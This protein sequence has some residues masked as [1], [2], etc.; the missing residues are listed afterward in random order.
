MIA[1]VLKKS[2]LVAVTV[3]MSPIFV[4]ALVGTHATGSSILETRTVTADATTLSQSEQESISQ[5][6]DETIDIQRMDNTQQE[7]FRKIVEDS[8]KS[9]SLP[10]QSDFDDYVSAVLSVFNSESN[11]YQD[12]S[13]AND[14]LITELDENHSSIFDPLSGEKILAAKHGTISASFLGSVLDAAIGAVVGGGAGAALSLVRK[15]GVKY[16]KKI[17]YFRL[18]AT[19]VNIGLGRANA[20]ILA[21]LE[22]ALNYYSPG[23]QLAKWVDSKDK[24][25]NNGWIE[26]W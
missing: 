4:G 18:K 2:V 15:K 5:Y 11:N 10:T 22:I 1:N 21:G 7:A 24:K 12:V 20:T 23:N 6:E 17:L 26:L 3:L 14:Q 8:T 25:R 9:L 19:L 13:A 16:V